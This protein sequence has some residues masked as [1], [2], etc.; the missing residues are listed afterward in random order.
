LRIES[1]PITS[2]RTTD[3]RLRKDGKGKRIK[4]FSEVFHF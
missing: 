4:L 2:K 3:Q 1:D